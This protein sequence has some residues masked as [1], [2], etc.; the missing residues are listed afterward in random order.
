MALIGNG[1][2]FWSSWK[3]G[4]QIG[5][6]LAQ[7]VIVYCAQLL[8]NYRSIPHFDATLFHCLVYALGLTNKCVWATFWVIFSICKSS[9]HPGWK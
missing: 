5:P 4:D 6:T 3:Q 8:E 1:F 9:G 2:I 7:W